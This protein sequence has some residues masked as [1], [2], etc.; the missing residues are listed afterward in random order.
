MSYEVR[1]YGGPDGW[2]TCWTTFDER[3]N[4][5]PQTFAT[6]AEA[7]AELDRYLLEDEEDVAADIAAGVEAYPAD[8]GDFRIFEAP[9]TH[10][11]RKTTIRISRSQWEAMGKKADSAEQVQQPS[12]LAY[13][14]ITGQGSRYIMD[15][16]GRTRR[17]KSFHSNTGSEDTGLH[18]W[19]DVAIFTQSKD[20][21]AS[22]AGQF[23]IGHGLRMS[24]KFANSV[25]TFMI[26]DP[27]TNQWRDATWGDAYPAYIKSN[28]A[29]AQKIL[30]F[31]YI[32]YPAMG[33]NILEIDFRPDKSLKGVHFGSP[34]SK[35]LTTLTSNDL[36]DFGYAVAPSN[37]TQSNHPI[38]PG[39]TQ[40]VGVSANIKRKLVLNRAEWEAIGKKAGWK[41]AAAPGYPYYLAVHREG[42][43]KGQYPA[44]IRF[45]PDMQRR[46]DRGQ[47]GN[48][49]KITELHDTDIQGLLDQLRAN[50]IDPLHDSVDFYLVGDRGSQRE[51][52]H[53]SRLLDMQRRPA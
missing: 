16:K 36:R 7:Q 14:F 9:D 32:R 27:R 21:L 26:L 17:I 33:W 31:Q 46:W 1:I 50:R 18:E 23:L 29:A 3:G 34:V 49:V 6:E 38:Q 51:K 52:I 37:Q 45:V 15:K 5:V 41:S 12:D 11:S 53:Y 48:G 30:A 44:E 47:L 4:E 22:N 42:R 13:A 40:P 8:P 24:L 25:A 19:N 20:E 35:V 39:Q 28:P 43:F 10:A 2:A